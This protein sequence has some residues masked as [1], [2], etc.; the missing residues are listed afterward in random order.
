MNKTKEIVF[1]R[2]GER[3]FNYFI[4]PAFLLG[5]SKSSQSSF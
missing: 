1:R 3:N 5:L 4:S 2:P